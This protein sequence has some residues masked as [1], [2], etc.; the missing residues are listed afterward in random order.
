MGR[1]YPFLLGAIGLSVGA[2]VGGSL[3][4]TGTEKR[5]AGPLSG[6]VMRRVRE[7]ADERFA[8]IR[9]TADHVATQLRTELAGRP[10]AE[11]MSAD[12]ETVLGGGKPPAQASKDGGLQVEREAASRLGLS[13]AETAR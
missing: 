13:G 12:F 2:A 11:D 1:R 3:R 10:E 7:A 5:V 8:D 4:L 9:D 6:T